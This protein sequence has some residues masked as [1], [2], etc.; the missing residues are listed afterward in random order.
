MFVLAE[1]ARKTKDDVGEKIK[2]QKETEEE[3]GLFS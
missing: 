1:A 3:T 2:K